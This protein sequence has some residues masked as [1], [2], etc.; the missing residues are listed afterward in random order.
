LMGRAGWTLWL[1]YDLGGSWEEVPST[2]LE[3]MKRDRRWCQGNLQHLRLLF[4]EGLFGAHRALFLNGA[5]SYMSALLWFGFLTLGAI[6]AVPNALPPPDYFRHGA[7]LFPVWPIWRPVWALALLVVIGLI[8]FFP[9]ALSIVLIALK[10]REARAY[11]GTMRLTASVLL[12]IFLS[13][14]FAPIRMVFHSRF[15]LMNLLGRTVSWRSQGRGG[16]PTP[17]RAALPPPRSRLAPRERLG[18]DALLADPRLLLVG[19]AHH[20]RAHP[21]DPHLGV[22]EP[23]EPGR[24]GTAPAA[25]PHPG[26]ERAAR[27]AL[28]PAGRPGRGA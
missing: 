5:L 7:S 11:G 14:L 17:R 9:K 22:D 25:L 2:L 23:R 16:P 3:E 10:R 8:L 27:R 28:R 24:P 4:T 6:Q 13:S 15:V 26:G 20:R 18:R 21:L 12:E 19:D 1:A